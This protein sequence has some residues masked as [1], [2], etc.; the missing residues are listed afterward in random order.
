[1]NKEEAQIIF[2]LRTN[3]K[4]SY[5]NLECTACGLEEENGKD[6]EVN[7]EKLLN[8]TVSEKL[9]IARKFKEKFEILES[10]KK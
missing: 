6:E 9:I 3:M 7:Y 10:K 5:E 8:A 4:G 2:K 1:M